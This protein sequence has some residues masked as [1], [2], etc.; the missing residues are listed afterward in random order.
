MQIKAEAYLA[1]SPQLYKQMCICSDFDRVFEIAP[2]FRAENSLTHRHMTEFMGLDLEMT[3]VEHYHEVL[4]LLDDLF[5]SLFRGLQVKYAKEMSVIQ[6]QFP[7]QEFRFL[8]KTLRL[9]FKDAIQ[10]LREDGIEIG[11]YDDMK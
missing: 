9:H 4:D 7:F 1:Q 11:D 8:D 3:F 10:M 6:K 5:L 2:V